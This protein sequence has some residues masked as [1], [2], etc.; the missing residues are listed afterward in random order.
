MHKIEALLGTHS[1]EVTIVNDMYCIFVVLF[2]YRHIHMHI[3][4][5]KYNCCV[6]NYKWDQTVPIV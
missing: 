3:H 1:L 5:Q 4:V 6:L 2:L